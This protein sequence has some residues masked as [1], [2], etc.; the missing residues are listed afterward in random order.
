MSTE[1]TLAPSE[2]DFLASF[3]VDPAEALPEDGFWCYLFES[4][5]GDAIRLSFD[6]HERSVQT[7][8]ESK[9]RVVCTVVHENASEIRIN[10]DGGEA[11]ISVDFSHE[12]DECQ[13]QLLVRVLPDLEI[14]WS[15]L[16]P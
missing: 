4:D 11:S 16:R 10:D 7:V 15:S 1:F 3:G 14:K 12:R 9:G 5:D 2:T 6:I 13:T 8:W